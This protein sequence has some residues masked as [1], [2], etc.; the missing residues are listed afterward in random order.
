MEFCPKCGGM[1]LPQRAGKS[2]LLVCQRCGR[3]MK[4]K[5]RSGYRFREKGKEKAEV[6]VVEEKR[7]KKIRP[8]EQEFELEPVEYY[9]EFFEETG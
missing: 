2:K 1:M 4:P 3:K 8:I 9:E 6:G 7:K 5:R